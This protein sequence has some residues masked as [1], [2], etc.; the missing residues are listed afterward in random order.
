M[1]LDPLDRSGDQV[2]SEVEEVKQE[3]MGAELPV[4][5]KSTGDSVVV[6]EKAEQCQSRETHPAVQWSVSVV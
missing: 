1:Y 4:E 2:H 5:M 3:D 6:V